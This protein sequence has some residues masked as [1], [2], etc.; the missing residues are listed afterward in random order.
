VRLCLEWRLEDRPRE[1][2][3]S[4]ISIFNQKLCPAIGVGPLLS[5]PLHWTVKMAS[6]SAASSDDY[7]VLWSGTAASSRDWMT[8]DSET[9]VPAARGCRRLWNAICSSDFS[10]SC[11]CC[12]CWFVDFWRAIT[13]STVAL[14]LPCCTALATTLLLFV[15]RLAAHFSAAVAREDVL[16]HTV[17]VAVLTSK[18]IQGR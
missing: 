4:P 8:S 11:C 9:G 5:T 10:F 13:S 3:I 6:G 1:I 2:W 15:H 14:R 16:Q 12:C 17:R 18:V 7:V